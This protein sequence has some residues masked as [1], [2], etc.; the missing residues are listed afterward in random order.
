MSI[1]SYLGF[2]IK[3]GKIIYGIDSILASK[4]KK[5]ALILSKTATENLRKKAVL[6]SERF[7][8][9]LVEVDSLEELIY[10]QNCKLVA[11]LDPN[12]AKAILD[13]AWR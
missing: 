2:A 8:I 9:P 1:E 4:K 6:H 11:V 10:K 7:N 5:Y 3:S 13:C 12:L